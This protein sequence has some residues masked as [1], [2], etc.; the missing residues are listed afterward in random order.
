MFPRMRSAF[1]I[2]IL[3]VALGGI[4]QTIVASSPKAPQ[5]II[6]L[7]SDGCGYYHVDAASIYQYGQT[8]TQVYEQFPVHYAMCT[9][10]GD[11]DGYDPEIA[12]S[13][14]DYVKQ[15][16]TQSPA[17]ATAA[18]ARRCCLFYAARRSAGDS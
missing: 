18:L 11:G 6:L 8:G 17:A 14:F 13:W 15:K 2:C 4:F 3:I 16:P 5:N 10:S 7:I 1:L 9:Y 12:W